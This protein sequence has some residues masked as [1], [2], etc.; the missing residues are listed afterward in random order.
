[1]K[2]KKMSGVYV[3][4]SIAWQNN[5]KSKI[6]LLMIPKILFS[7]IIQKPTLYNIFKSVGFPGLCSTTRYIYSILGLHSKLGELICHTKFNLSFQYS[8]HR[9]IVLHNNKKLENKCT[10]E[11]M[12]I[13]ISMIYPDYLF[14]FPLVKK[15]A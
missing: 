4:Y 2:L 5:R 3:L 13:C 15:R 6:I 9:F 7:L 11:A 8:Q 10:G 12:I 1:M 14:K